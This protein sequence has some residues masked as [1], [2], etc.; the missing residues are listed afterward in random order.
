MSPASIYLDYGATTPV[1][2]RVLEAMA[3]CLTA[4]GVF[5]NASSD[6]AAGA[7]ARDIVE[8]VRGL[9]AERIGG[10]PEGIV[11][12]SGATEANNLALRGAISTADRPHL[13]TSIIEHRSVLDCARYLESVGA[14]LTVLDCDSLGRVDPDSVGQALRPTTRLVSIMHANNEVG[15]VQ[16]IRAI[17]GICRQH[18]VPLHVDA[19]QSAG[20]LP[21]EVDAWGI[22]LCSLTAHKLCGPK[23]VGV[24]Y[25]RPGLV[26]EPLF[27]GGEQER[28]VRPGTLATHQIAGLGRAIELAEPAESVRTAALRD[29]LWAGLAGIAGACR[30]GDPDDSAPHLLSV[31]FPGVD[32]ESLRLALG[33]VAVSQG[34]ACTSASPEASHV[35]SAMGLGDTRA[36]GTLR[37][38]LGRFTT[39]WEVDTVIGR[40]RVAVP[41]LRGL[42]DHAP[43]WCSA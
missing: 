2:P 41:R 35:L 3:G 18:G 33:D 19:A 28:R 40:L 21:L 4:D 25:V 20:K 11:F 36:R 6:H 42:A 31:S 38:G 16:D 8:A 9:V 37:F 34:S 10:R 23:G 12:T 13:I 32:G 24:L 5:G 7:R 43:G 39:E 15:T 26:L 17:A 27:Y 22:D 30:N 29:R 14:D 1:D